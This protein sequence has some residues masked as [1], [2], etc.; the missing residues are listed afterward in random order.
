MSDAPKGGRGRPATQTA[1]GKR[2]AKQIY[3]QERYQRLR[4]GPTGPSGD[5]RVQVGNAEA[6]LTL[7]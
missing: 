1:E 3:N 6:P 7:L 5:G 4:A 2:L